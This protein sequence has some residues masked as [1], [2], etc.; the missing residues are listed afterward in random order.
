[1]TI[2]ITGVG[3][4]IGHYLLALAKSDGYRVRVFAS[5]D[6]IYRL[7]DHRGFEAVAGTV[8]DPRALA[9]AVRNI[10]IVYHADFTTQG[11]IEDMKRVNAEGTRKLL[12]ACA[13]D[14]RRF[15]LIGT[16]A[17]YASHPTPDTW[18]VRADAPRGPH[19]APRFAAY[20]HSMVDAE[21]YL[22]EAA[23]LYGLEY[24]ILRTGILCGHSAYPVGIVSSLMRQPERA[25][26]MHEMLG[27]MQWM[28]GLDAARAVMLAGTHPDARNEGFIVAGRESTT[29]FGLLELL[30]DITHP[31]EP[32]PF[33]EAAKAWQP[34]VPK[35]DISKIATVLGFNPVIS[36]RKCLEEVLGRIELTPAYLA[37]PAEPTP[38]KMEPASPESA[39]SMHGKTCVISGATSGIG[40]ACAEVLAMMGAR[41]V[42]IGR[43][44]SKGDNALKRLRQVAPAVEAE[45]HYGDLSLLEDVRRIAGEILETSPRIDILINNAGAVFDRCDLTREGLEQGFVTNY[46]SHFLMTMLL[47]DRLVTSA[48]SRI[49]T[50]TSA[51]HRMGSIDLSDL[52]NRRINNGYI[53]YVRAKLCN[54]LFTNELA[55]QLDGSGVVAVSVCPGL[56]ATGI[57]ENTTG[58]LH[59]FLSRVK[60][61]AVSPKEAGDGLAYIASTPEVADANGAYIERW[62]PANPS[63]TA[64][65]EHLA[66]QLW[67]KSLE[68]AGLKPMAEISTR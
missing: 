32:N 57:G 20:G 1:M 39:P 26:Q 13:G 18:P 15:V 29:T 68:L 36:L 19:G 7:P 61:N 66:R 4:S 2:L 67:A 54:V 44:R 34:P 60:Q 37:S 45:I 10:D 48:P 64:S 62:Q 42:L 3:Q 6:E 41:L 49:I 17:V 27:P 5:H 56:V 33:G 14:V 35:L 28:H 55:S 8:D 38:A 11:S 9:E 31:D 16:P 58:Q 53:A 50:L 59:T 46:L 30:W 43:N 40:L 23:R 65:D 22:V 51:V 12:E 25:E 63:P 47:K 21:D 24:C 52:T